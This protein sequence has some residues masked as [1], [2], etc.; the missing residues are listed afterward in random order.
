MESKVILKELI[1]TVFPS[2]SN[3]IVLKSTNPVKQLMVCTPLNLI[4]CLSLRYSVTKQQL[5]EDGQCSRRDWTARLI[6]TVTGT[7]TSTALVT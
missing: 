3:E 2:Q 6:F 1:I 7:T 5:V 4:T